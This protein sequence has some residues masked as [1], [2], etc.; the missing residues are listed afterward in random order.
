M[1][2]NV[3]LEFLECRLKSYNIAS[4]SNFVSFCSPRRREEHY[5]VSVLGSLVVAIGGGGSG[6]GGG[7]GLRMGSDCPISQTHTHDTRDTRRVLR[8]QPNTLS[9][10]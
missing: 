4:T 10:K 3:P 2:D 6:V 8:A 7:W 1:I 5:V 9:H